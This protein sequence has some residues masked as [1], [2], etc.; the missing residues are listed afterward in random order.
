M[1]FVRG[2][3]RKQ[4]G[5]LRKVGASHPEDGL[6]RLSLDFIISI[7]SKMITGLPAI[8]VWVDIETSEV[9]GTPSF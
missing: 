7:I 4:H 9:L 8:R 1:R 2:S 3:I 5:I 6:M